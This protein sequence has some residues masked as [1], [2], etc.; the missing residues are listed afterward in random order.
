MAKTQISYSAYFLLLLEDLIL[1]LILT[2]GTVRSKFKPLICCLVSC[3]FATAMTLFSAPPIHFGAVFFAVMAILSA[4]RALIELAE[5][6]SGE[7][8]PPS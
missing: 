7:R 6:R 1:L 3:S 5:L 4:S 2:G 8:V